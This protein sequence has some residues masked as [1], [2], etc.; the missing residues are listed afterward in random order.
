LYNPRFVRE[1]RPNVAAP[2]AL[3]PLQ[4]RLGPVAA[5]V[6]VGDEEEGAYEGE[7]DQSSSTG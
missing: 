7:G 5:A 4:F 2:P 3:V 1:P 6:E